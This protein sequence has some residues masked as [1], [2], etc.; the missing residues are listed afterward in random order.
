MPASPLR[1]LLVDDSEV[2]RLGLAALLGQA[3][4]LSIVAEAG[5]V[6]EALAAAA[7]TRPD[8]VLLDIRLPD[9]T[10]FDACR[11]ILATHPTAR[12]LV[13][14]SEADESVVDDAIRAGAHV[15]LLK[16]VNGQALL[17]AIRAVAAG[18]SILDPA[19][20]ERVLRL[21]RTRRPGERDVLAA[22]S[23]QETKVL[24][25]IADGL[26][27]KEVA[28][29]LGLAEKTVRNYLATIFEKLHVNRRTQAA[30]LYARGRGPSGG[31]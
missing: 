5:T 16:E 8:V 17:N 20:T 30:A 9:G 3:P 31:G 21:M 18:Q 28:A 22:L 26:T 25:G 23:P 7:E 2:V 1:L 27:N 13:L 14:T 11:G 4:D 29:R 12:V 24:A 6:R 10:G 15:Y 19:I